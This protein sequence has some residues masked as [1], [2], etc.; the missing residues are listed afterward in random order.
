M[1]V[2]EDASLS[3]VVQ[4]IMG[5]RFTQFEMTGTPVNSSV[6]SSSQ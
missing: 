3:F 1:G 4:E 6:T 5:M 2:E